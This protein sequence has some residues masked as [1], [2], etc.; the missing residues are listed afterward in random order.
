MK[1]T[2]DADQTQTKML[3][4]ATDR[5]TIFFEIF[6]ILKTKNLKNHLHPH[7]LSKVQYN[8]FYNKIVKK[9]S[10]DR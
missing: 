5:L 9:S 8:N 7:G 2:N 3:D 4:F 10:N 1:N 6:Q